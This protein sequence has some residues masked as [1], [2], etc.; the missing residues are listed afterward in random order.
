MP[1]TLLTEWFRTHPRAKII[2]PTPGMGP[3]LGAEF[4]AIAIGD[5]AIFGTPARLASYGGLARTK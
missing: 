4:I 1:G 3:I 2:D 5:L